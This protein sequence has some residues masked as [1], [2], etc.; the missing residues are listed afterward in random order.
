MLDHRRAVAGLQ[1][2]H[3]LFDD[4]RDALGIPPSL[5]LFGNGGQ[6]KPGQLASIV[7][8]NPVK[9]RPHWDAG[10]I[11]RFEPSTVG[12]R[13]LPIADADG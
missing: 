10:G 2:R 3:R 11:V 6:S 12:I 7:I 13:A 4:P 9:L 5:V 1:G 8:A